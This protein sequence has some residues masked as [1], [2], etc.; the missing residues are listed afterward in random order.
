[1]ILTIMGMT[2][3]EAAIVLP[4][5]TSILIFIGGG[6]AKIL[7]DKVKK[8]NEISSSRNIVFKWS[9]MVIK[10]ATDQAK[11]L[12][13]LSQGVLNSKEL[14]PLA[15]RFFKNMAD[16][17]SDVSAERMTLL[18]VSNTKCKLG[19]EDMRQKYAFNIVSQYDFLTSIQPEIK[20]IYEKYNQSCIDIIN[21][22]GAL[23]R[24][25]Q[26]DREKLSLP[27][28]DGSY[29]CNEVKVSTIINQIISSFMDNPNRS[30]FT[31]VD[32]YNGLI[33][34]LNRAVDKCKEDFPD[35]VSGVS[36]YEDAREMILIYNQWA[37]N[38]ESYTEVF[39]NIAHTVSNS[40]ESLS[41]AISYFSEET[42]TKIFCR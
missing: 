41:T 1:M 2:Y 38:I 4:I 14:Y 5:I 36:L 16:K 39:A 13:E 18:F 32:W 25:T 23:M 30:N 12:S 8:H 29:N 21:R 22:W 24:K 35:V 37:A 7:S 19:R 10:S 11:A 42:T 6:L 15:F 28:I 27:A 33:I 26:R 17:L 34:P 40:I 9:E 3:T 20:I 31:F